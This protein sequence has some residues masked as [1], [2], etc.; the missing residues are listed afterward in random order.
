[1]DISVATVANFS[2]FF[3]RSRASWALGSVSSTITCK[4]T[5]ISGVSCAGSGFHP[6]WDR[7]AAP[8]MVITLLKLAEFRCL[9]E[10]DCEPERANT[11]AFMEV[12]NSS[13]LGGHCVSKL[14][15]HPQ[16]RFRSR[17][18]LLS[19]KENQILAAQSLT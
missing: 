18:G 3:R 6:A 12:R 17:C 7:R 13:M 19:G 16:L 1:M 14:V 2:P 9:K 8:R 15:G 5:F 10:P 4:L 11:F